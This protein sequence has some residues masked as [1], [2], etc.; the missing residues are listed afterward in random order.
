M[1][2][3]MRSAAI[4]A[5]L[6]GSVAF[7]AAPGPGGLHI[8]NATSLGEHGNKQPPGREEYLPDIVVFKLKRDVGLLRTAARQA[9]LARIEAVY[10][11]R[12]AREIFPL[13][14]TIR[15]E[16][17]MEL[18]RIYVAHAA[19]P[20]DVPSVCAQLGRD[21][22][23]EYAEPHFIRHLYFTPNDPRIGLQEYLQQ[24]NAYQAWNVSRGDSTI[25]VG[26]VDSGVDWHHED[27]SAHIWTNTDGSHGWDFAG[28]DGRTPDNDPSPGS[29]HGTHVAGIAGAV[30]NNGIGIAGAGYS[31]TILPVKA[32]KDDPRSNDIL[33]GYEGIKWAADHGAAIIN[34]SWGGSGLSNFEADVLRSV[35]PWVLIVAAAG[36]ENSTST[37]YP[38]GYPGVLAVASVSSSDMK[39]T[40][41][42]YG[43]S[44]G[45]SAPGENI[46][47]TY[48]ISQ[49]SYGYLD[50]TS[51]AS[52]VVTGVAALVKAIHRDWLPG[53]IAAQVRS[54]ALSIDAQNPGYEGLLGSGRV[55]AAAAVS[56]DVAGLSILSVNMTS[57]RGAG[58]SCSADPGDT[59][60][61]IATVMSWL[62]PLPAGVTLTLQG[63][64]PYI[65][66]IQSA[67]VTG[68]AGTLDSISI[69]SQPLMF[70]V[71][72]DVPGDHEVNLVLDASGGGA[73]DRRNISFVAN[74]TFRETDV[75]NVSV[76][77][78]SHGT[79]SFDDYP[80]NT[81]G[82]GFRYKLG[83]NLLFEG[84]IVSGED[85]AHIVDVARS[86]DPLERDR[87][88]THVAALRLQTPGAF[89]AQDGVCVMSDDSAGAAKIGLQV[90]LESFEYT[91][92]SNRDFVMLKYTVRN[93]GTAVVPAYYFG[94]YFDWDLGSVS[95]NIAGVDTP[96][97]LGYVYDTDPAGVRA[98]TGVRLL[99]NGPLA[100]RAIA[101]PGDAS[102][103][104]YD[105]FSNSEKWEALSSGV[106]KRQAGPTD[107][108]FFIGTG[109]VRM[110]PGDSAVAA[111]AMI[112]G[113]DSLSMFQHAAAAQL[114]WNSIA[115]S[116]PPPPP[117]EFSLDQ[118]Y[119]NPFNPATTIRYGASSLQPRTSVRLRVFDVLGREVATLVDGMVEPGFHRIRFDAR[120]L[121][122][123]VYYYELRAGSFATTRK[124]IV[125][126]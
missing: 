100:F 91:E 74:P 85:S 81:R 103:G 12:G 55:D 9:Q 70:V 77:I 57:L 35:V 13:P 30:T 38:A 64:D 48:P 120:S 32:G 98:W 112:A 104:V 66:F 56:R 28:A 116:P 8:R 110:T 124:M 89:S 33:F 54:T 43:Y 94:L 61:V 46:Y 7:A 105:G 24:I 16:S 50:G 121:P 26:I 115:S 125:L 58:R 19:G 36:N 59:V 6:A 73:G 117:T 31:V 1:R 42:N 78:S 92:P 15:D 71:S 87:G 86:A 96:L 4:F 23:V 68:P 11:L 123:G 2:A 69:A 51:M 84:A 75:N 126:R 88:I 80:E 114:L 90:R 101:N 37:G 122:S 63:S 67:V 118:N 79:L 52:P 107:V 93:T 83:P 3:V 106:S 29:P 39:S 109:P 102:W 113:D 97:H 22:S 34:C 47:S 27:L 14:E 76:T 18:S 111:F 82:E 108:S 60:V 49:G 65:R 10:R 5:L 119:P 40:F 72:R 21:P 44:V 25:I 20:L 95:E 17:D 45:V 62:K 53:Q 99:T 41:S